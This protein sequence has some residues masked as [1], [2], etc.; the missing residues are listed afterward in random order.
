MFQYNGWHF[1]DIDTHFQN[2]VGDFPDTWYQQPTIDKALS[3]V[4]NFHCAIDVGANVGLHTVRFAQKFK[5]VY[6]FEPVKSNFNC[7]QKNTKSLQNVICYK[8]GVGEIKQSL[9]IKI[10]PDANN[11]G[12]YSFV[13]FEEFDNTISES[14]EVVTIDSFNLHPDLIKID[15]Q[16]FEKQVLLGALNTLKNSNPVIITEVET[17]EQKNTLNKILVD[18]GYVFVDNHR[19]DHIWIKN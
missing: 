6:S 12:A 4:K 1:P 9:D 19:R 17:K 5:N 3:H 15:T 10:P 18:V 16:G 2:S 14:V 8:N 11:C 13:D 7:L